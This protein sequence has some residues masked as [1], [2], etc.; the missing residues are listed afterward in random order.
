MVSPTWAPAAWRAEPSANLE[1]VVVANTSSWPRMMSM[2]KKPR[3]MLNTAP[4]ATTRMRF[5]T[6]L[7]PK[8]PGSPLSSSSPSMAQ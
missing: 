6:G 8:E 2:R 7:P 1:M 5:H 3:M 4:A